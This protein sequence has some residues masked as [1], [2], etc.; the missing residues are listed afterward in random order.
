MA[1]PHLKL[2]K[3]IVRF[4]TKIDIKTFLSKLRI[5]KI[6]IINPVKH[7]YKIS[8]IDDMSDKECLSYIKSRPGVLAAFRRH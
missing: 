6:E 3:I 2:K 7:T 8:V 5:D 1:A 4:V